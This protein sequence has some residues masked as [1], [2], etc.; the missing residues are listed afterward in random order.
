VKRSL[1]RLDIADYVKFEDPKLKALITKA[2]SLCPGM[3][4][5]TSGTTESAKRVGKPGKWSI[6]SFLRGV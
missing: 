6:V 1:T 4:V 5:P 2:D 3:D